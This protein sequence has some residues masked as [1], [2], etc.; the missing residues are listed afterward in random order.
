LSTKIRL[1]R[2]GTKK[3]PHYRVVVA[4]TRSP[5]DGRFIE[6]LGTYNPLL[7]KD[8]PKRVILNA[9]RIKYWLGAG[10]QPTDRVSKFLG[11]ANITEMPKQKNNPFKAK[12]K[13]KAQERA[14]KLTEESKKND[15]ST[16]ENH[17]NENNK[18]NIETDKDPKQ[19][20]LSSEEENGNKKNDI[21]VKA[22]DTDKEK[23]SEASDTNDVK[24]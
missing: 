3:R 16:K 22:K 19:D 21:D 17:D 18:A 11:M 14:K 4:D 15:N 20:K 6:R 8:D 5:R 10:A 1:S 2:G 9:D 13:A 12:P 23:S 24:N 7:P